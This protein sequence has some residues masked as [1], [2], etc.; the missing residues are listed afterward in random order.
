LLLTALLHLWL[1]VVGVVRHTWGWWWVRRE[2]RTRPYP[3]PTS[4]WSWAWSWEGICRRLVRGSLV[5]SNVMNTSSR[6]LDVVD[7][8]TMG[9]RPHQDAD[10][11]ILLP[12][13]NRS[14]NRNRKTLA[15]SWSPPTANEE[16][17]RS[18]QR[19]TPQ[20]N[21]TV[22]P[23]LLLHFTFMLHSL[24]TFNR[25]MWLVAQIDCCA[26]ECGGLLLQRRPVQSWPWCGRG[27]GAVFFPSFPP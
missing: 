13:S 14:R 11:V 15:S 6:H 3:S 26:D 19:S 2:A 21:G 24:T 22:I 4:V 1:F 18:H 20:R 16:G 8:K 10:Y 25:Q 7:S 23:S 5:G 9:H 17:S 27:Q 12:T